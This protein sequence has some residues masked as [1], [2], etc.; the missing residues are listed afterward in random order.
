MELHYNLTGK[1]KKNCKPLVLEEET[2][3][4]INTAFL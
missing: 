4:Q 3:Q 1:K 2:E